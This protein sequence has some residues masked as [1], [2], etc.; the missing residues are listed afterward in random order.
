MGPRIV[1]TW[2]KE[3]SPGPGICPDALASVPPAADILLED[4]TP[5]TPERL[6]WPSE[7]RESR[8]GNIPLNCPAADRWN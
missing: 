3:V 1:H 5:S 4:W 6:P 8:L 7:A 2:E